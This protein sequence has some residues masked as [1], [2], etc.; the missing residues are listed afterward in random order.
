MEQYEY[1]RIQAD[2][3]KLI[4]KYRKARY[5]FTTREWDAYEQ[6]VLACK[7]VLSNFNPERVVKRKGRASHE[8]T[9]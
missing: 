9:V 5:S 2:L 4:G 6:A 3:S 1:D 7:S 8:E